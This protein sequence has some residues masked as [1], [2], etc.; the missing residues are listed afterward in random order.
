M[1]K[2]PSATVV[3]GTAELSRVLVKT[4]SVELRDAEG[5]VGDRASNRAFRAIVDDLRDHLKKVGDD[6]FGETPTSDLSKKKLDKVLGE[7]DPEAAGIIH[8]A[9]EQ[10]A[11][12]FA[13]VIARFLKLKGWRDVQRIA[14]GG[15]LRASRIG[16]IA[17]GR[18]S[19]MLKANGHKID[20][21]PIGSHPDEAGLIGAAFLAPGWMFEGYEGILAVDIGGSN[22]RAGVVDLHLKKNKDL[23]HCTVHESEIWRYVDDDDKPKRDQAVERIGRM[24]SK[25]TEKTKS[26]LKLAPFIGIAC[27]G[28]IGEDGHIESGGQNLPGNWQ[29]RRFNLPSI[30]RQMIPRIGDHDTMVVMHNDAVVQGLSEIP[31]MCDTEHWGVLT[32]GTGLGNASFSNRPAPADSE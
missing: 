22:V 1:K 29:S 32:I 12:E 21:V 10:F 25:L 17:I 16:E 8:G 4:Y 6:P 7:G 3:H 23:S 13:S 30:I 11:T 9:V 27:P 18:T 20:L 26:K 24:L 15:G 2:I 5:F 19:V 28:I 31:N 14:V